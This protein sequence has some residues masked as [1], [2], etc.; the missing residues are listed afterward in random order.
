MV[1]DHR[2][3]CTERIHTPCLRQGTVGRHRPGMQQ[4]LQQQEE[5][6]QQP[7]EELD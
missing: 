3:Q 1:H 7:R 5:Q 6:G 4:E 2:L